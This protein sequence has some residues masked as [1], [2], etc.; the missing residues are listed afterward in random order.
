RAGRGAGADV[1]AAGRGCPAAMS[2]RGAGTGVCRV[3]VSGAC[4]PA[5][6]VRV[7]SNERENQTM[8][9]TTTN[10]DTGSLKVGEAGASL[11]VGSKIQLVGEKSPRIISYTMGEG[12]KKHVCAKGFGP[13]PV[14]EVTYEI[15]GE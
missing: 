9:N 1:R 4:A 2:G 15:V 14:G 7:M 8:T 10:N 12:A 5:P 6:D 3:S 11:R 13:F